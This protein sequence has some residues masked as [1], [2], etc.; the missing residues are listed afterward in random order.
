M[1]CD[2]QTYCDNCINTIAIQH[3][4][5]KTICN[6]H[7]K[8]VEYTDK[9]Y[10]TKCKTSK[11]CNEPTIDCDVC[12]Q[13]G[14]EKEKENE[15]KEGYKNLMFDFGELVFE[16]VKDNQFCDEYIYKNVNTGIR[17]LYD[18]KYDIWKQLS[19]LEKITLDNNERSENR[20][21]IIVNVSCY[22][23]Y[24]CKHTFYVNGKRSMNVTDKI[25]ELLNKYGYSVP[26]CLKHS[27]NN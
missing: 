5:K 15:R 22:E 14:I 4:A 3:I 8:Y 17:Y 11:K 10:C 9:L 7:N 12:L 27:I 18:I 19:E 1:S 21:Q 24:P 20:P 25:I 16:Y 13:K 6:Q 26:S 2:I 23:T